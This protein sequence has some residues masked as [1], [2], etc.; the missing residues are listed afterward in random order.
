MRNF[1]LLLGLMLSLIGCQKVE[2]SPAETTST[3]ASEPFASDWESLAKVNESPEWFADSKLGIYFHW[4]PYTV[5]AFGSEWYPRY[6]YEEES[7]AF[8]FHQKTFGDQKEFG[9]HDFVPMFTAEKFNPEEWANI[10]AGAG[11]RWA[12]PVA[13]HHDGFAMWDSEVNPWNAADMGPKRDITGEMAKAI[14]ARGMKLIT[15]FHHARN[16]QRNANDQKNWDGW[17]SHFPYNPEWHTSSTDEQLKW[18]YGNVP[19]EEW[20]PYWLAQLEEVIDKYDPDIIWFDVWL[21]MI[22][23]PRQGSSHRP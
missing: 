19:A 2:P 7:E 16:L 13:Q 5:P 23:E 10:I 15:S 22:P 1:L 8:T 17:S 21:N 11:A 4:G 12:G 14:R 9:Y 6:M 20:H 18:L 3:P